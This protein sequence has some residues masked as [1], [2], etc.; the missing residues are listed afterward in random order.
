MLIYF[1]NPIIPSGFTGAHGNTDNWV[2]KLSCD[3]TEVFYAEGNDGYG[4]FMSMLTAF[5][6]APPA[7][8]I[9][10]STD[11]DDPNASVFPGATEIL[12]NGVDDD[13]DGYVD[14]FGTKIFSSANVASVFSLFPNPTDGA[15]V[16]FLQLNNDVNSE[17]T[18]E[19]INLLE[20]SCLQCNKFVAERKI[21]RGN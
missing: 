18:V 21:G 13:C 16:V 11:C 10:D 6:C 15:F 2:V 14:E 17:A 1:Y 7:G 9:T 8:Y 12:F 4:N 5:A 20:S 19:V 3:V